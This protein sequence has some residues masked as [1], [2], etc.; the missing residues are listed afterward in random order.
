MQSNQ[1]II[2]KRGKV[3]GI[4]SLLL[5]SRRHSLREK[6][7]D[8][9]DGRENEEEVTSHPQEVLVTVVLVPFPVGCRVVT[10]VKA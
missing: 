5:L 3:V 8:W 1:K 6:S 10:V 2:P 4:S 7:S 9:M